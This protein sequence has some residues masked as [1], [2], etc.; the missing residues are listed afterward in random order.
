MRNAAAAGVNVWST[1]GSKFMRYVVKGEEGKMGWGWRTAMRLY[2]FISVFV[3][4][5][6]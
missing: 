2:F 3:V 1:Q 6:T 5:N 4:V